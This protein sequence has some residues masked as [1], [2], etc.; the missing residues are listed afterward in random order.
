MLRFTDRK[1]NVKTYW[2]PVQPRNV[3]L[4]GRNSVLICS[5]ISCAAQFFLPK[6]SVGAMQIYPKH[7]CGVFGIFGHPNAAELAYYG[8]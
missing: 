7:Y 4:S 2:H 5:T 8:L 1:A 6:F 3:I